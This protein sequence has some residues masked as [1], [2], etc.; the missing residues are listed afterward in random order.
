M[1]F[2]STFFVLS[3]AFLSTC[4]AVRLEKYRHIEVSVS[5]DYNLGPTAADVQKLF[6]NKTYPH[7]TSNDL[8]SDICKAGKPD[9]LDG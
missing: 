8:Y 4:L 2:H 6:S 7:L 9:S 1:S 3:L 5:L